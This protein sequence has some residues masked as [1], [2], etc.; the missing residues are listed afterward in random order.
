MTEVY[1]DAGMKPAIESGNAHEDPATVLFTTLIMY[2][3]LDLLSVFIWHMPGFDS[4][5]W[6][7]T[8]FMG[9]SLTDDN[10]MLSG[11]VY[12]WNWVQLLMQVVQFVVPV[13]LMVGIS[14]TWAKGQLAGLQPWVLGGFHMVMLA[15]MVANYYT[16]DFLEVFYQ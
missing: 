13:I 3:L 14:L 7:M 4:H 8:T 1:V 15:I 6:D 16:K 9:N 10:L 5:A 11:G 12:S 2:V